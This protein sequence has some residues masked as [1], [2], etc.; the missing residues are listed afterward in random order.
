MDL[1]FSVA[2]SALRF[3]TNR[4]W[5]FIFTA[6]HPNDFI[7]LLHRFNRAPFFGWL[8]VRRVTVGQPE[9]MGTAEFC[10]AGAARLGDLKQSE[11]NAFPDCR[12]YCVSVD[13]VALEVIIG[14]RQFAVLSATVVRHLDFDS[15]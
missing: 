2:V 15:G 4:H 11:R 1:R 10:I 9:L 13:A 3:G 14:H 12:R 5:S 7:G 8:G 6:G